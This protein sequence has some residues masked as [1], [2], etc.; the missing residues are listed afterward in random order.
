MR[1]IWWKIYVVA[2]AY[3]VGCCEGNCKYIEGES[4]KNF[5]TVIILKTLQETY[6]IQ[7]MIHNNYPKT[8]KLPTM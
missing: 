8:I 5:F 2:T 1:K 4:F 6:K 7:H 3:Y